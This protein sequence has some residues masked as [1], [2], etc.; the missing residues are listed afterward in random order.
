MK[1]SELLALFGAQE[2]II[3]EVANEEDLSRRINDIINNISDKYMGPEYA[4]VDY[5]LIVDWLLS[6]EQAT[7][8]TQTKF[9]SFTTY[10]DKSA[11]NAYHVISIN[12]V[13]LTPVMFINYKRRIMEDY[14][15]LLHS[16]MGYNK[17]TMIVITD[18][19]DEVFI[20]KM[21]EYKGLKSILRNN[22]ELKLARVVNGTHIEFLS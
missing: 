22:D 1:L 18:K 3:M 16:E 19:T 15:G 12:L 4:T 13:E 21:L 10:H 2:T 11:I 20:S 17:I 14:S 6:E 5:K 7:I 9:P 8:I